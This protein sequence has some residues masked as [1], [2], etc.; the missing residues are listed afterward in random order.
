MEIPPISVQPVAADL[1]RVTDSEAV[2]FHDWLRSDSTCI[3][4]L[5]KNPPTFRNSTR[6]KYYL[7]APVERVEL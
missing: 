2:S 3:K 5:S 4:P 1:H 6:V 7:P